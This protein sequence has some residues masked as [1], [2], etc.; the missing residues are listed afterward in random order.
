LS[1]SPL[2]AIHAAPDE[3]LP[4]TRSLWLARI[5][6][7]LFGYCQAVAPLSRRYAR[8]SLE[9]LEDRVVPSGPQVFNVGAGDTAGLIN[10]IV[11]SDASSTGGIIN[12]TAS[13]YDLTQTYVSSSSGI[14]G[15]W[16]G[17]EGLPPITNSIT[18][19][20]NGAVIQRD[21]KAT[22]NFRLF[23]ISGGPTLS[24]NVA[25]MTAGNLTLNNLTLQDGVAKGGNAGTGGG[26]LGA[27]GAIFNMGTLTLNGDTLNNNSAIGG[28]AGI[29]SI[30]G[31]G[32]GGMGSDADN[33]GNG[34]GM[35]GPLSGG[36]LTG[37]TQGGAGN[38]TQ[39]SGG[40]G[41]GFTSGG[42]GL[43][44]QAAGFGGAGGGVTAFAT[45][46]GDGG[47]GGF[48]FNTANTVGG[49]GGNFGSG[50][51][52]GEGGGGGGVGGGG[53][54]A[55][56]DSNGGDGGDGG[57]GGG[58]GGFAGRTGQ[59]GP[60]N[61]AGYGGFGGGDAKN[62][63]TALLNQNNFGGGDGGQ[64]TNANITGGGGGAGMGGAIFTMFGTVTIVNCTISGNSATGG[65]AATGSQG[66]GAYGGGLFNL[67]GSV[68]MVYVTVANNTTTAGTSGTGGDASVDDGYGVYNLAD[69]NTVNGAVVTAT[70]SLENS[71]IGENNG[72]G[73]SD[74]ANNAINGI[75][76]NTAHITGSTN[77]AP[78][79]GLHQGNGTTTVDNGV[80]ISPFKQPQLGPLQN[81]GGPTFT[82]ALPAGTP[83][84][85][86]ANPTLAGL[87]TVD[88]R[89]LPRPSTQGQD[90]LGAFQNQGLTVAVTAPSSP[91]NGT[92]GTSVNLQAT[93]TSNGSPATEGTVSFSINSSTV[94]TA[95]VNAQGQAGT[96]ATL[97]ASD[98]AGTYTVVA[99]YTDTATP[100]KFASG[101]G[102]GTLQITTAP[103]QI[104]LGNQSANYN[105]AAQTVTLTGTV[106]ATTGGNATEGTVTFTLANL[107]A[108]KGK[109]NSSGAASATITLPAGM[110]PGSYTLSASYADGNNANGIPNFGSSTASSNFTI[111]SAPTTV[112]V[113]NASASYN[114]KATQ[115]IN[116]TAS[117]TSVAGAVNA[118]NITFT[119]GNLSTTAAVN[120][121]GSASTTLTLPAG[122]LGGTY[123]ITA[124]YADTPN[125]NGILLFANGTGTGTLTVSPASTQTTLTSTSLSVGFNSSASQSITLTANATGAFGPLSEGSVTFTVANLSVQG[126]VSNGTATANLVLPS[127]LAAG[128]YTIGASYADAVNSQGG[129]N[130]GTSASATTG[131]LTVA[132]AP[133]STSVNS[134]TASYS[135]ASQQVS[136]LATVTSST[137]G[138]VN[139]GS[140][141]FT[142][143]SLPSVSATVNAGGQASA[144]L[145][146][147][148]GFALGSYAINASYSDSLNSNNTV[149][150]AASKAAPA[151]LTIQ[152]A[153]TNL[154]IGA[155]N[156]TFN[157][158]TQTV[159]LSATVTSPGGGAVNEGSVSFAVGN[160]NSVSGKVNSQGQAS[161]GFVL[162]AGFA[163]G[164]YTITASYSDAQGNF[165]S[166]S[167]TGTLSLASAASQ[168]G[169]AAVQA[170]F[171]SASQLVTV[172]ATMTSPNGGT[173]NEGSVTF[174]MPG[175]S[176]VIGQ[177]DKTGTATAQLT[178][179]ANFAAGNYT[180][181]ANYSDGLNA[182][183][184]VNFTASNTTAALNVGTASSQISV[185][186]VNTTFSPTAS[187]Q[188]TLTAN[189]TSPN[190]GTVNEGTVTFT[191]GNL[192]SVQGL[193]SNGQASAT[194]T[195]PI[196][197]TAGNYTI[198]ASYSDGLNANNVAN[199]ASSTGTSTLTVQPLGTLTN[200][201]PATFTVSFNPS[202]GSLMLSAQVTSSAGAVTE[203][204]VAFTVGSLAAVK[205]GLNSAGVASAVIPL[206]A[207][208]AAGQ[209][210]ITA[211]YTD[212][213]TPNYGSSTS[214]GGTLTVQ[215]LA[216]STTA[217]NV[218]VSF[219]SATQQATLSAT[220]TGSGGAAVNEGQVT[221][222][223]GN[224]AASAMVHNGSA[225]ATVTLPAGL[226]A[227]SYA[228]NASY[229]DV[230]NAN[231][232]TNFTSSSGPATLTV[233][234]VATNVSVNSSAVV[235]SG[236][237][238][239]AT[240]TATVSAGNGTSVNE[241]VVTFTAAGQT[242]T[243]AVNGGV[244]NAV[245][246]IPGGAAP[247]TSAIGVS[248]ADA[249]NV[250]GLLNFTASAGSGALTVQR[251]TSVTIT[252][253]SV[254]PGFGSVTEAVTAQVTSPYGPVNGGV[255]TFN[256]AGTLV[257]AGVVNGTASARVSVPASAA[258]GSQ[259]IS[260]TFSEVGGVFSS[261]FG[262]RS[263]LLNFL[264][265]FFPT[266]VSIAAD[267]SE[268][269]SVSF[270]GIPLTYTYNASGALVGI[271]IFG[272]PL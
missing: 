188:V 259:G 105:T 135:T 262:S 179:P 115:T 159:T 134:V 80:F 182:N 125:A 78:T 210:P 155:V 171:N 162:P 92:S 72:T 37:L 121:S 161:V 147:P 177:V 216:T 84:S 272:I 228:V 252:Q 145:T 89:G 165:N 166:V 2:E 143:G 204:T 21:P 102:S 175:L 190:G 220:V 253:V 207:G 109:V 183:G 44:G 226:A 35:G 153:P 270:F 173:V 98:I 267:G 4:M 100:P 60:G 137:G 33:A 1:F 56:N 65:N 17:P 236:P 107:P 39:G 54:G 142:V 131:T 174:S 138:R 186:K 63:G 42:N 209:Y 269:V 86:A 139:E 66:G 43:P 198:N 91:Y 23:F 120:S 233:S 5:R 213:A 246:T 110:A 61:F 88:Q 168:T 82:M 157:S 15:Y 206:P 59:S 113:G 222:T 268:V 146:L 122:F 73:G 24:G 97:P 187:Q 240:L 74:L 149:D 178:L 229:A 103:T 258:G 27:G 239:Q 256:V 238:Q 201:T 8:L 170:T 212:T 71:I 81:N 83:G 152:P 200:L 255:V 38:A 34:G 124:S 112:T 87:P 58:G 193:V 26:G 25:A 47:D 192:S 40:G 180:L 6:R 118:G 205:A 119:V 96:T 160:L 247:G 53:G 241:G 154:Q 127:G 20:G 79:G 151:Q 32:G 51:A 248:Y 114:P 3:M 144:E 68:S 101:S 164:N 221:F 64:P 251:S 148:A 203:G 264:S 9:G 260:A 150:F 77:L 12:L 93:V 214:S 227:G 69:A 254:T 194:L 140:V 235:L 265:E 243:A 263:A 244:A 75:N 231:G 18:I 211:S 57:F 215:P 46:I 90:D 106:T 129:V 141:T 76:T 130:Y 67:D 14:N 185:G 117:V 123:A 30:T 257:Q 217:S 136:L 266:V 7:R 95:T 208:F 189:V 41:G 49:N 172:T 237:A 242:I 219:N 195:L 271:T 261:S 245:L 225:T 50:G 234:T 13:T 28:S 36:A 196:G 55:S 48:A 176:S 133:T 62:D 181:S 158:A 169:V 218:S 94:A 19:N 223:V 128:S 70:L 191:V 29:T 22:T 99:N 230:T 224:L 202:G 250:N 111:G 104:A 163:A 197:F 45:L 108:V 10:A 249:T 167:G 126:A 85:G 11:Q 199:Y 132:T 156:A 232:V 52:P 116:L 31:L 184:I 16:Y